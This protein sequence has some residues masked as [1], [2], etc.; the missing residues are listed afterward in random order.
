MAHLFISYSRKD[1][2]YA[3]QLVETLRQ[4][5]LEAWMDREIPSGARWQEVLLDKIETCSAMVVVVSPRS[6]RSFWVMRELSYA[7]EFKKPIFPILMEGAAWPPLD[8]FQCSNTVEELLH[9][10]RQLARLFIS[11]TSDDENFASRLATDLAR[12]GADVWRKDDSRTE[13]D[14]LHSSQIMLLVVSASSMESTKVRAEWQTF[15]AVNKPIIPL[16]VQHTAVP[17]TIREKQP[18]IDFLDQDYQLAFAQLYGLLRSLGVILQD[19]EQVS[20]PPQPQLR[21]NRYEMLH[22]ARSEV[23]IS[24][25]TL[26]G[27][28]RRPDLLES[29]VVQRPKLD[30]RLLTIELSVDLLNATGAWFG[31]N[32]VR[33]AKLVHNEDFEVWASRQNGALT[34]EGRWVGQRLFGSLQTFAQLQQRLPN[35]LQ[36]RAV[37]YRLGTGFLITDPHLPEGLLTGYPYSYHLDAA[38]GKQRTEYDLSPIFLSKQSSKESERWWFDKYVEE[39]DFLWNDATPIDWAKLGLD[40]EGF[41]SGPIE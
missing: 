30:I 13:Q 22:E 24:G 41:N 18:Y 8:E 28:S 15:H 37:P 3:S 10:L 6:A 12:L 14:G 35:N 19:H 27:F 25:I 17:V 38:K 7:H 4:H 26:E 5:Q 33:Y 9:G 32:E 36:I 2:D 31:I 21:L 40:G 34:T 39:F 20:I 16:L 29:A 11:Y 1:L 23:W